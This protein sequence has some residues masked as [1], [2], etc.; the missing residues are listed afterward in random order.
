MEA[1]MTRLTTSWQSFTQA[2]VESK[3][4]IAVVNGITG[5][6]NGAANFVE[7]GSPVLK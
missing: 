4:V 2:L 5:F 3:T 7:A 6:I 1:A